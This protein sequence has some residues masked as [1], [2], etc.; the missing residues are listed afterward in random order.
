MDAQFVQPVGTYTAAANGPLG[1]T[2]WSGR[3]RYMYV[4]YMDAVTYTTGHVCTPASATTYKVTN[5][6]SGGSSLGLRF[7]GVVPNVNE[8]GAAITAVPTQNAYGYIQLE[9][10]HSAVLNDGNDGAAG[11]TCIM[12]ATDGSTAFTAAATTT[13]TLLYVG[14]A[15]AA[16]TAT[17]GLIYVKCFL[18]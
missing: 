4:Q 3:R 16:I 2:S 9:G 10:I 5:D 11:D 1:Q 12:L 15:P 17:T 6:V 18:W 7:A 8:N 14:W 13:G